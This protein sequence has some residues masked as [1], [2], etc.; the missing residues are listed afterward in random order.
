MS[1]AFHDI[2]HIVQPYPNDLPAHSLRQAGHLIHLRA[3]F[4]RCRHYRIKM[5]LHKCVF[6]IETGRLLGFVVSKAGIRVDPSKVKAIVKL[7]PPSTL[8]LLQSFLEAVFPIECEIPSLHI[9]VQLLPATSEEEKHLLYLAQ[10]DENR[11][12]AALVV[13][14]HAK[15]IKAQYDR[16]V[17]PHNF[18][19]GDLVLLYYQADDKLGAGKFVPMWHGQYIVKRKLEK[20]AYEVEYFDGVSLGKPRN[21]LHLKRYYA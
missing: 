20:G 8:R 5:N 13:E 12:N 2:K 4:M 14:T 21:G 17:T 18:S 6:C 11:R 7:P 15:R 19:E 16:N 10:L 9:A 1:Y 3:I